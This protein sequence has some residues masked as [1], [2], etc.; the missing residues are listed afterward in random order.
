MHQSW[1]T[2]CRCSLRGVQRPCGSLPR[3]VFPVRIAGSIQGK[4]SGVPRHLYGDWLRRVA[5]T[6]RMDPL[7]SHGSK[8]EL[9]LNLR[10]T[11]LLTGFP[12]VG[13]EAG[14]DL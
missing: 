10:P 11:A 13:P 9:P 4:D 7:R 5:H 1:S 6:W 8:K 2:L 3:A 12:R 14:N